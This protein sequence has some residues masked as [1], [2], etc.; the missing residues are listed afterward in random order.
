MSNGVCSFCQPMPYR[1][2]GKLVMAAALT[3]TISSRSKPMQ[4]KALKNAGTL[5]H[6]AGRTKVRVLFQTSG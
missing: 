6:Q 4:L 2:Y 5:I 3:A 1:A